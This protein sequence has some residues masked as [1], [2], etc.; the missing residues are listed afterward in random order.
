MTNFRSFQ[1]TVVEISEFFTGQNGANEG[2]TQFFTVENHVGEIVNF[3]VTPK[4]FFV[5]HKMV[6][7]GDVITAYYDG[8]RPVILIYPPQYEALVIVKENPYQYVKVDFFDHSL[9]SSDRQ[10]MINLT[11]F[12]KV[13]LTNGQAFLRFPGNRDLI[14]IYGAST[15]SIPAI[16]TPFRIIVL[17]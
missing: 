9:V 6:S 1:G 14:V 2:C 13:L 10:L 17:C 7:V 5:D 12:T 11:P 16:T 15:K 8:D 3:V 4:T